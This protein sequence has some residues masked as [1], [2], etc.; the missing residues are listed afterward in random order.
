MRFGQIILLLTLSLFI[1]TSCGTGYKA[2]KRK[3][4]KVSNIH[5]KN[6]IQKSKLNFTLEKKRKKLQYKVNKKH[7]K[8]QMKKR[9]KH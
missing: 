7:W 3:I 2:S 9:Y 5:D 4:V 8:S 1:F 6:V